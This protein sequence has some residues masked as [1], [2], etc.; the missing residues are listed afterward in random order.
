MSGIFGVAGS[1]GHDGFHSV[2]MRE[3]PEGPEG[4][5]GPVGLPG[6]RGGVGP[7]GAEGD[8][9][10]PG[11][12]TRF[13]RL[14][15]PGYIQTHG[16]FFHPMGKAK[17]SFWMDGDTQ[18]P[19]LWSVPLVTQNRLT[20]NKH[21]TII[22]DVATNPLRGNTDVFI[23]V[24]DGSKFAGFVHDASGNRALG[25]IEHGVADQI[26]Q[27]YMMHKAAAI[28]DP[29][30]YR[31]RAVGET[32]WEY[33]TRDPKDREA[34]DKPILRT[35][36]K[37]DALFATED[38]EAEAEA[39]VLAQ[40]T[41]TETEPVKND[42]K[43]DAKDDADAKTR[44]A[45]EAARKAAAEDAAQAKVRADAEAKAASEASR[46]KQQDATVAAKK[47][48]EDREDKAMKAAQAAIK[49]AERITGTSP[50][51]VEKA[52]AGDKA[53]AEA[54]K[55]VEEARAKAEDDAVS[56]HAVKPK[57][58]RVYIRIDTSENTEVLAQTHKNLMPVLDTVPFR[59]DPAKG[60]TL[61]GYADDPAENLG[62]YAV[63]VTIRAESS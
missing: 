31:V 26:E 7:R 57:F 30:Q 53:A 34:Q 28:K 46:Q 55:A 39:D 35:D 22:L 3:G 16:V 36:I 45:A 58:F 27:R 47:T 59:L 54:L 23:G 60:L 37:G 9:G 2:R 15:T 4:P 48:E 43:A 32:G 61:V 18:E 41:E 33:V 56:K 49:A 25:Q 20:R 21:Y 29:A 11:Q 52:A 38:A 12:L 24:S 10:L 62:F 51:A 8:M 14:M 13:Y 1:N 6:R 42:A 50:A 17:K 44:A 19:K 63:E 5:Q 40:E